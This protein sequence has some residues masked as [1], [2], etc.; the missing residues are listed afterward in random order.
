MKLYTI[1]F[2]KKSAEEFFGLLRASGADK[3]VDV[4]LN[5]V[6]QLAGFAKRDDLRYFARELCGMGY[7]HRLDLAPTRPLLDDYRKHGSGWPAYAAGFLDLLRDRGVERS[8]PREA[9]AD[10]VLLCSE[11]AP[12]HCHRRLVAEY[13]AER[14]GG[15]SVEHLA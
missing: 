8:V 2:T 12:D 7:A 3:V 5:N 1:G 4:R 9:L 15:V 6:S 11:D 10:A 13:L 14:W